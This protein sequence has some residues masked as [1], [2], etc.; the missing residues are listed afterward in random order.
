MP[1]EMPGQIIVDTSGFY[2]LVAPNDRYHQ[3]AH[4]AFA[5]LVARR[6]RFTTTS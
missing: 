3:S 4:A 2:A 5:S 6:L 1:D